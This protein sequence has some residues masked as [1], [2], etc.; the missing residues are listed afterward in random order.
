MKIF[1]NI[2]S[3][4]KLVDCL[5]YL[6]PHRK[7][8]EEARAAGNLEEERK[9][10]LAATSTWGE[11][12]FK[13]FDTNLI[14]KGLENIPEKGP[15]VFMGNHQGY[16]DI[17]AYCAAFRKFQFGFIA[18][19]ELAKV[20]LYG[21]WITRI[22]SEFIERDD[23][24]SSLQTINKGIELIEQGFSMAIFPEGTRSKC[25]QPN[26]FKKGAMKLATKPG[27]PIIPVTIDGSYKFFEEN[28][29]IT[30][31]DIHMIIHEPIETA[32]LDRKAEKELHAK[33]EAVILDGLRELGAIE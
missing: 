17:F 6:R 25:S 19:K 11:K 27:V 23:P 18:K 20:P 14:V 24:R 31:C 12:I 5:K 1:T 33:V 4:I 9:H 28:G 10:I 7:G 15:V 32:G 26:E 2:P 8:I 16:A 22:R 29:C 3:I 13:T 21:P 30:P